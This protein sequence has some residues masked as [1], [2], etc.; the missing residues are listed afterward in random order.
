M[1]LARVFELAG[2]TE[3][4]H[5][6]PQSQIE[7]GLRPDY[8]VLLPGGTAIPVDAKVPMAAFLDAQGEADPAR[9]STLL[10]Q[11]SRD[12]R[13]HVKALGKKDYAGSMDGEIDFTVMFLPGDH[14]LEAAFHSAP[15]LQEDAMEH[16]V[17]IATPVTLLALLKTVAIYW[18][19]DKLARN[20]QQIADVAKEYHKRM[21]TFAGHF[22]KTGNGLKAAVK[23]YNNSVGSY[24]KQVAPQGR[25]LEDMA[26]IAPNRV[27]TEPQE[28]EQEPR[29][30]SLT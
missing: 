19:Q 12:L 2:M 13:G 11:H 1:V 14:L 27:I 18:Q 15:H 8:Q 28:L 4:V 3:G 29:E 24:L 9:R 22:E 30:D 5:F 10:E 20:A 7:G 25:R 16:G 6:K 21:R 26:D 23:A 17:L